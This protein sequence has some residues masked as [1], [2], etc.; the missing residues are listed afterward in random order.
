MTVLYTRWRS[1]RFVSSEPYA[2]TIFKYENARNDMI[3][4]YC[5]VTY[6]LIITILYLI[7]LEIKL[8]GN[9]TYPNKN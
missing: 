1:C 2:N 9:M 3:Y 6:E 5:F 4:Q 7:C 8:F